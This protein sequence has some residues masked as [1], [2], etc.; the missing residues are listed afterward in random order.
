VIAPL[1][2]IAATLPGAT[3][4]PALTVVE[5][6]AAGCGRPALLTADSAP[7]PLRLPVDGLCVRKAFAARLEGGA[8]IHAV[9]LV[10]VADPALSPLRLFIYTLRG[11]HL[12]PRYLGSGPRSLELLDAQRGAGHPVDVLR[13]VVRDQNG[14]R[15]TLR[16]RFAKFPLQCETWPEVSGGES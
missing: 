8:T 13:V 9:L 15:R 12:E 1:L 7:V 3:A 4:L 10:E 5:R 11:Q 6:D 16:C 2:F 14:D